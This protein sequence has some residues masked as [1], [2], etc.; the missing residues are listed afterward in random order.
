VALVEFAVNLCWKSTLVLAAALAVTRLLRRQS[1][2]LRHLVL[3]CAVVGTVCGVVLES[4]LPRWKQQLPAWLSTSAPTIERAE[5]L[6]QT[7]LALNRQ[8]VA[9]MD[10]HSMPST[11]AFDA[12]GPQLSRSISKIVVVG[13][14]AWFV[15]FVLVLVRFASA[16]LRL[17]RFRQLAHVTAAATVLRTFAPM[18]RIKRQIRIFQSDQIHAP[19][20][21]GIWRPVILLPQSWQGLPEERREVALLHELVHIARNDFAIRIVA[22][23][24]CA[25]FWFQPL[26]W[27]V[28][29]ALREE[30]ELA[31]DERVLAAGK[32]CSVYAK[33]LLYWHDRLSA[34]DGLP[35]PGMAQPSGLERRLRSILDPRL[36]RKP[37][38]LWQMGGF[39]LLGLGIAL[40]LW[41]VEFTAASTPALPS[42]LHSDPPGAPSVVDRGMPTSKARSAVSGRQ[43]HDSVHTLNGGVTCPECFQL[44]TRG[45][46][47]EI[48]GEGDRWFAT[49][50]RS[51]RTVEENAFRGVRFQADM[52]DVTFVEPGG[53]FELYEKAS[54]GTRR[55][56]VSPDPYGHIRRIW[57]VDARR[58]S[59][60]RMA[61]TW[62]ANRLLEWERHAGYTSDARVDFLLRVGGVQA[63]FDELTRLDSDGVRRLYMLALLK[64]DNVP[65]IQKEQALV[66]AEERFA[67][68]EG[69]SNLLTEILED[70]QLPDALRGAAARLVRLNRG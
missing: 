62:L 26:A 23:V 1:A 55:L 20:T 17:R 43:A 51:G 21:W 49:W 60:D 65:E 66:T 18:L 44:S 15:G 13:A 69:W 11:R 24:F 16:L 68:R 2:D 38:S 40:P 50:S 42:R 4:V 32:K 47:G 6:S 19:M 64:Q 14:V 29:R 12:V 37:L 36:R 22:D 39:W 67:T 7:G 28:R 48:L 46:F 59:F 8:A 25:L 35:A 34:Q 27:S 58:Q 30:Q 9:T 3:F 56:V 33:V 57:Y 63:V 41:S 70:H 45:H 53:F 10:S 52:S 54:E 5:R 61:R 31:C